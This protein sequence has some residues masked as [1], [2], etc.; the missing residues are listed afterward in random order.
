[1]IFSME[2]FADVSADRPV[3]FARIVMRLLAEPKLKRAGL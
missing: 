1:M 3:L 2:R